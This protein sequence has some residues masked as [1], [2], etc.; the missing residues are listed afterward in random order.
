M[1]A[2]TSG[3]HQLIIVNR[4]SLHVSGVRNVDS[5]DESN[6]VLETTHGLLH[7]RGTGLHVNQL[8]LE[9]EKLEIE[10]AID[11]VVYSENRSELRGKGLLARLLK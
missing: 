11:A 6:V 9:Q 5:F 4:E 2:P 3:G 7:V 1:P 10:G 8:N